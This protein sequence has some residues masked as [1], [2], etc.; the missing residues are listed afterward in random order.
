MLLAEGAAAGGGTPWIL[1]QTP[2]SP[3]NDV[4]GCVGVG[5]TVGGSNITVTDLGRWVISGNSQSHTISLLDNSG[6]VLASVAVATS[7]AP[8]GDYKYGSITP[9]VLTAATI[10]WVASAETNG[11]DQWYN[12]INTSAPGYTTTSAANTAFKAFDTTGAC[13]G[14]APSSGGTDN[15]FVPVNFKYH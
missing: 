12:T 9:T 3:R 8:I 7:A 14:A 6:T 5:F 2:E 1:T 11:G 4:D 13:G 10:Y 15:A